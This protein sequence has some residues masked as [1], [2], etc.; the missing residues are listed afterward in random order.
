V[1]TCPFCAEE[2]KDEAIKCR[3]CGSD[4]TAAQPTPVTAQVGEGAQQFSH[5]GARYLLGYGADF[6]GIWDRQVPGGPIQ[7]F[8]RT[9]DGWRVAWTTY[10]TMEPVNVAVSVAQTQQRAQSSDRLGVSQREA[11]PGAWWI[12]PILLGWLGGLIAWAV[13][14]HRDP[15][16]A[17]AMLITGILISVVAIILIAALTPG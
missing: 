7:R 1:K 15:V 11:V 13:T 5:S 17:R 10:A 4:L 16:M 6:F 9:D 14:R 3:Y 2:I 12:L 8:A